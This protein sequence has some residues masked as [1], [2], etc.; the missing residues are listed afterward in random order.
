LKT[1]L[2]QQG[3]TLDEALH[4]PQV[5]GTPAM[6]NEQL[7][8]LAEQDLDGLMLQWMDVDDLDGLELFAHSVL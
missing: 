7:A 6:V 2:A 3:M 1:K 4:S 5:V 8:F